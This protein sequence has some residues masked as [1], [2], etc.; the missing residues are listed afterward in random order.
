MLSLKAAR[1]RK[2]TVGE[3]EVA[4]APQWLRAALCFF[5]LF[6][7]VNSRHVPRSEPDAIEAARV[8]KRSFLRR[9]AFLSGKPLAIELA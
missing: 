5:S 1:P 7:K 2:L 6:Q 9:E 3:Q 4:R 8:P